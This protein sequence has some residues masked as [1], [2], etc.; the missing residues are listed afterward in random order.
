VGSL[1]GSRWRTVDRRRQGWPCR[2]SSRGHGGFGQ[3]W[4]CSRR[5]WFKRHLAMGPNRSMSGL[6]QRLRPLP[7]GSNRP[8]NATMRFRRFEQ[9]KSRHLLPVANDALP[10]HNELRRQ[11]DLRSPIDMKGRASQSAHP[12]KHLTK[13]NVQ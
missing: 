9:T 5:R 2:G 1:P 8:M 4:K 11:S 6:P 13:G 3:G 12:R 10:A 7:H